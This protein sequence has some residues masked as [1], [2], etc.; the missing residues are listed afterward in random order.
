MK[1]GAVPAQ[2]YRKLYNSMV[3][4]VFDYGAPV[5]SHYCS[6]ADLE[7]VQNRAYRFFLGVG[8]KHPLAAAAGD[9]LDAHKTETSVSN[10]VIVVLHIAKGRK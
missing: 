9:V 6:T 8:R 1:L 10:L 4:S 2:V 3:A 5:W 7:K